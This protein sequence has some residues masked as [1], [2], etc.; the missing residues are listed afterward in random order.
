MLGAASGAVGILNQG[1]DLLTRKFSEIIQKKIDFFARFI[2]LV[3]CVVLVIKGFELTGRVHEQTSSAMGIR[4]SF[5]YS[6]VPVG[7]FFILVI[8]SFDT[9]NKFYG[10]KKINQENSEL[11]FQKIHN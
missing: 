5:V 1:I 2:T 4:M 10:H 7:L 3:T 6:A 11:N 8:V 9:I